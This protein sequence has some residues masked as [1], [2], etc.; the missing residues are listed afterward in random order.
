MKCR[1]ERSRTSFLRRFL[2]SLHISLITYLP[3]HQWSDPTLASTG[4]PFPPNLAIFPTS[5]VSGVNFYHAY[6]RPCFTHSC[7]RCMVLSVAYT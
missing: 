4:S 5:Y 2:S 1:T 3:C 6:I 7:S